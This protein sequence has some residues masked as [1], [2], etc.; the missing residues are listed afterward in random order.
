MSFEPNDM[1]ASNSASNVGQPVASV[2]KA[3]E[4]NG[5]AID[6]MNFTRSACDP[7]LSVVVEACAGSGKTWLLVAR[8]LRLLLS[9]AEPSE[10]LAIT[11]TRKAAQEMRHRLMEL[12][13]ELA[14]SDH[15]QASQ[16]LIDRGVSETEVEANLVRARGLYESLLNHP[17]GL[18]MDTFHSW[19]GRLLQLAPLAS[20]VPQGFQL[21]EATGQLQREAW[22]QLLNR[23]GLA[24]KENEA[25]EGIGNISG[26]REHATENQGRGESSSGTQI[27]QAMLF[28]F[29][30]LGDHSTKQLLDAFLAKRAEWWAISCEHSQ[31]PDA[32]LVLD[33]LED[34]LGEDAHRDARLQLWDDQALLQEIA[35]FA[36]C[37]GKGGSLNQERAR[38]LET[39]VTTAQ[40]M[41]S[42]GEVPGLELF[43]ALANEFYDDKGAPRRNGKVKSFVAALTEH[44]GAGVG[45]P[46]EAFNA[47]FNRVAA[48]IQDYARRAQEIDVLQINRALFL[49]GQAYLDEY[50]DIKAA[51]GALDFSDLEWQAYRLLSREEFAAYLLGRLDARYKHILLD[52]FQ[53]TNPL[54][55]NIVRSWLDA[56][57]ADH[58]R[59]TVF[60]VG[61]P[62]Q[63]I[64]RFRRADPRVFMA[65]QEMLAQQGA[66]V[67]KTNQTR[68]NAPVVIEALNRAMYSNQLYS[69]QTTLSAQ[70]GS[71]LRLPLVKDVEEAGVGDQDQVSG[72]D[73]NQDENQDNKQDQDSAPSDA[74]R[75]PLTT[76]AEESE[77]LSRYQE[78]QQVARLLCE[79][80]Q[81]HQ[82]Q[83]KVSQEQG[84]DGSDWRWSDVM[85]LVRRR[86]YLSSY[87]RALREVGI[88]FVSNRRGGLLQT[89]EIMDLMALL[90][91]LMTPSDNRALAHIL[92]SP[93]FACSDGDLMMLAMRGEATWWQR[94]SASLSASVHEAS[95]AV[96]SVS[97]QLA[98]QQHSQ[99]PQ[100]VRAHDLLQKWMQAAHDLPVHDLLD[101]ILHQGDVL[102]RYAELNSASERDQ[103]RG[104]ILGFVELALNLDGGRYPSLPKFIASIAEYDKLAENESP[105]ESNV[106][107]GLD[108]VQILTIHSAKGLEAK[109]VV[110]LD[111][112]HSDASDDHVGVLCAWPLRDG[113]A[114][115]FSIFG[116]RDQR[117]KARDALF[118]AEA[119]QA[120]QENLNLLYVAVT[121]AKQ[122]LVI[123]GVANAKKSDGEV[124]GL[125]EGSWYQ[126]FMEIPEVSLIADTVVGEGAAKSAAGF[127]LEQA[128][129]FEFEDFTPPN[130]ALPISA[131]QT[132]A[133]STDYVRQFEDGLARDAFANDTSNS[134]A[135]RTDQPSEAQVEG[136]ALHALMERMTANPA[137]ASWSEIMPSAEVIAQWL[138]CPSPIASVV[139]KQ[140]LSILQSPALTAFFDRSRLTVARNEMD[141]IFAGQL[142]RLDRLVVFRANDPQYADEVWILD[143]KRQLLASERADYQ[144]QLATY[145]QA[146]AAVYP[147]R[148][149]RSALILTDG[150][151]HEFG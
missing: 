95:D 103:V 7:S 9:G 116:R 106:V 114:K 131:G 45:D 52:E 118:K 75:R 79:L 123:S 3:Y 117:G 54:Q 42:Q 135:T 6:A 140:A 55:W 50:Q 33:H 113:E 30:A 97:E 147:H 60:V 76:P 63:S 134:D 59:P 86:S 58:Q 46:L 20:G 83:Q 39:L 32:Q 139:R 87:E 111:A 96:E 49:V 8:M 53:D 12:L 68:R 48:V 72:Q 136:I 1:N 24:E 66:I 137:T 40:Q 77:N 16:I 69:P 67:L 43:A 44:F 84:R 145:R 78:G 10:L 17:Q 25:D 100:L 109:I 146:V 110:M 148:K 65:A 15:A 108:A 88:P 91:F 89:L 26:R 36:R 107:S 74:I 132:V 90:N 102:A 149:I 2:A 73:E 142:L 130:L 11:F 71:V 4:C 51:Q 94:L 38:Q 141:I 28:L 37:L 93:I 105:D 115:H 150:C 19:F 82:L 64:Y 41:Q 120:S 18:A 5:Q 23:V 31:V 35:Q 70:D 47:A 14:L 27:R 29:D 125:T 101:T 128:T 13:R 112:N 138:P 127:S 126:A 122:M 104:N 61:D 144:A 119:D 92:K 121:R 85:L 56:Y 21:L 22:R 80:K 81:Q 124:P 129:Q 133:S 151:L 143:Y 34:V 98:Q 62:K 99:H 57:G